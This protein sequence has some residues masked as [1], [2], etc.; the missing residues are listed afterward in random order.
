MPNTIL[1]SFL[2]RIHRGQKENALIGKNNG[3]GIPLGYLLGDE[4]KLVIDPLT[5]PIVKEIFALKILRNPEDAEDIMQNVFIAV[6][7]KITELKEPAA[8]Y[9]W[10]NQITANRCMNHFRKKK[11]FI[12]DE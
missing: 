8:Y 5:A 10:L 3:G 7:D 2:R 11:A 9:K 6:F 12:G 1:L 4:Q